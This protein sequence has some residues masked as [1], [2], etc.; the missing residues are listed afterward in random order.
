MNLECFLSE[1]N[2]QKP[3]ALPLPPQVTVLPPPSESGI[4]LW[5]AGSSAIQGWGE[6]RSHTLWAHCVPVSGALGSTAHSRDPVWHTCTLSPQ[7][8]GLGVIFSVYILCDGYSLRMTVN[9]GQQDDHSGSLSG[10]ILSITYGP[11]FWFWYELQNIINYLFSIPTFILWLSHAIEHHIR[12]AMFT[13]WL[14]WIP[15]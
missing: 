2:I 5:E 13:H 8:Q 6:G 11:D 9:V 7:R 10:G 15:S 12:M 3:P 14:M 1:L 4:G